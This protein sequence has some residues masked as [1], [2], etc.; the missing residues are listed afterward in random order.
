[1]YLRRWRA[2]NLREDLRGQG[3]GMLEGETADPEDPFRL[4]FQ[5]VLDP[6]EPAAS[7]LLEFHNDLMTTRNA[8]C[9]SLDTIARGGGWSFRTRCYSGKLR[10]IIPHQS[11]PHCSGGL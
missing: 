6:S 1:V 8:A 3:Y 10:L 7:F 9:R 4:V 11:V 2:H 5:E